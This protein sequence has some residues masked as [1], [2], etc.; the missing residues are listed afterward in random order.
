MGHFALEEWV[1]FVRNVVDETRGKEMQRHLDMGCKDCG[2]ILQT[3]K[4]VHEIIRGDAIYEPPES[5]IRSVTG[6]YVIHGLQKVKPPMP[7]MA[8]LLFDSTRSGLPASVRSAG[9]SARQLLYRANRYEIDVRLEPRNDS[10][11]VALIGQIL[12]H[13]PTHAVDGISVTLIRS[14]KILMKSTTNTVGE[15]QFGFDLEGVLQLRFEPSHGNEFHIPLSE[16][17]GTAPDREGS[18]AALR[19]R[20]N[21]R[22]RK[23]R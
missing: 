22:T 21:G 4:R 3:W 8:R 10:E 11:K 23:K 18:K 17:I 6:A 2:P 12:S 14:G 20:K 13:D 5:A 7:L 16:S 15:F 9:T 1:D 19:A